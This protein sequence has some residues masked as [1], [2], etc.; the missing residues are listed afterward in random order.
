MGREELATGTA[1]W[2][3]VVLSGAYDVNRAAA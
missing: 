1:I 2:L 3:A